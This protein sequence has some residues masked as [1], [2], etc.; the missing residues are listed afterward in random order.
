MTQLAPRTVVIL[1]R[2]DEMAL[3]FTAEWKISEG[4]TH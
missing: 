2:Q 3:N 4:V 1:K